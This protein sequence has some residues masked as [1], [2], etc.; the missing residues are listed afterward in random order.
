ISPC[1]KIV[2]GGKCPNSDLCPQVRLAPCGTE[3]ETWPVVGECYVES[4]DPLQCTLDIT[5]C[6][7]KA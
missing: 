7:N 1:P 6:P 4:V 3:P 2:K 5:P